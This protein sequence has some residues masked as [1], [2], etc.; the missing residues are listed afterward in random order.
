MMAEI[1]G[2]RMLRKAHF[3]LLVLCAAP[4]HAQAMPEMPGMTMPSAASTPPTGASDDMGGMAGMDHHAMSGMDHE[5]AG[6]MAMHGAFGPY[7]MTREASGTS[8]EPDSAPVD[9]LHIMSGPWM[10]MVHGAA[11]LVHDDQGGPRGGTKTFS[12]SML[13]A[14]ASRSA[15]D[16]GTIGLRAML[17]LDPLMGKSGYP[18]L[19]AT[20]ETANGRDELVDRQHPHDLFMEL[21]ASYSHDLGHGRSLYLYGGL[22]GE[23]ALGPPTFMHRISGMD[24]PEAPIGHHWFD[25]THI[26][27]GVVTAGFSGGTWKAE[28][29]AFN[30]REPDQHRWNI[31]QPSLDSWSVRGFWNPTSNLSLQL[32]TG[33]IHSP[34]QL[35]PTRDEQR[36]TASISY[37]LPLP[38]H[39]NWAWTLGWAR[40]DER[41]GPALT[42][43]LG[44]T[45]L[46]LNRRH[47]LFARAEHVEEAELFDTGPLAASIIPVSKL[48][49]GYAYELPIG[50]G[51][52]RLALGGLVSGYAY[53]DRIRP[54]YGSPGFKSFMLFARWRLAGG[55]PSN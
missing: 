31:E 37:N 49:A 15:G 47:I 40:K 21:S 23:P 13:M 18:L 22:P 53:P 41:P 19:F 28:A 12:Q 9:G 33:H 10:V 34:E 46:R 50:S 14:M 42:G 4:L 7:A 29:S 26:T 27:F 32:S 20:G 45:A 48:S 5:T 54:A 43:W 2:P 44:E 17:S 39:G 36:T 16:R 1:S 52:T 8:W 30:G 51:R 24:L 35:D 55:E 11:T 6:G 38:D 25:S 3:S